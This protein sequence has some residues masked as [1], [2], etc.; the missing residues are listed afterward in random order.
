MQKMTIILFQFLIQNCFALQIHQIRISEISPNA[1]N[2]SLD[3]EA[4][5]LY[6]FNS[7]QYAISQNEITIEVSFVKGF[8]SSIA[9]LNNNFEIPINTQETAQR[10]LNLR[11]YYTNGTDFYN[12]LNLQDEF[13]TVFSTPI[14]N[15]IILENDG[16]ESRIEVD[17]INPN[18]GEIDLKDQINWILIYNSN[19]KIIKQA[20][21]QTGIFSFSELPDGFCFIRLISG[22]KSETIK[23]ILKK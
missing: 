3:T 21:N 2:V 16:F 23:I 13:Q 14:D 10:Q 17:Y 9:Y 18:P 7:W 15:P 4:S 1:I 6:Y 12:P 22:N 11:I 20:K 5:E 19:G 8:G